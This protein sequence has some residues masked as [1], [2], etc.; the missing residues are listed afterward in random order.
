[1]QEDEFSGF[2]NE[3]PSPHN[4][5]LLLEDAHYELE[6]INPE[7]FS[8]IRLYALDKSRGLHHS[9]SLVFSQPR[10]AL[11]QE[12][13]KETQ[14]MHLPLPDRGAL[15]TLMQAAKNLYN[16]DDK[17]FD[18]NH[19]LVNAALGLST[20]EAQL[21]FAKAAVS[22]KRLTETEIDLIIAEKEQVIKKQDYWN[23]STPKSGWM[24]LVVWAT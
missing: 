15:R 14:I 8:N 21:A 22:R 11:P 18:N 1:M 9:Q 23:I 20:S 2:D 4:S 19:R 13:E 12:L 5:I 17:D 16:L 24:T 6:A 10:Q 7:L 3:Q